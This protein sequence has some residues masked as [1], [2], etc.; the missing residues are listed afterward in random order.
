LPVRRLQI[1]ERLSKLCHVLRRE[2]G[3]HVQVPRDKRRTVQDAGEAANDDEFDVSVAESV[4][5]AVELRHGIELAEARLAQGAVAEAAALLSEA[6]ALLKDGDG[7]RER[8]AR[9]ENGARL[10]RLREMNAHRMD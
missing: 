9:H 7:W 4:D 6:T 8:K 10:R 1:A 2:H 3:A 5:E